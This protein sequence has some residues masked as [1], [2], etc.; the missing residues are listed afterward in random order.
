MP[1]TLPLIVRPECA[2]LLRGPREFI[3]L[4]FWPLFF[5]LPSIFTLPSS[6][7]IS[8]RPLALYTLPVSPI[9]IPS[10]PEYLF[11]SLIPVS[12]V[13]GSPQ[14]VVVTSLP[15]PIRSAISH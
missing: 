4:V 11:S 13:T 5:K 1:V 8:T 2:L 10:L 9:S 3:I 15:L 12:C 7:Y 14:T 6:L